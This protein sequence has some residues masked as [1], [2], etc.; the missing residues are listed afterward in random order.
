MG[1]CVGEEETVITTSGNVF[2]LGLLQQIPSSPQTNIFYSPYSIY[3]ALAM[4]YVGARG[5]TQHDLHEALGYSTAGLS[6]ESVASLHARHTR[7]LREPSNSTLL[8]ANAVVVQTGYNVQRQYLDTLRDSFGAE[9]SEADLTDVQSLK[10]INDWVKNKTAGQIEQLLLEPLPSEAKLVLLNAIYFKGL[11]NTPFQA[12]STFKAPFFNA[13]TERVQVDTMHQQI[14]A[15]YAEDDETNAQVVDLTYAGL[16][17]SMVI[18]LPR[19]KNGADAIRR[20]FSVPLYHRLLLKLRERVVD[21]ALPKFKIDKLN[22]LKSNLTFL[23][24]RKMFGSEADLS[25]IT[26]DRRLYVSDVLQR[27]V[28]EVNEEGTE[29]A[30]VTGVIGVNRI[31]IEPFLFT[32]DHPFLFF[33]RDRKTNEI[34]FAGQVNVL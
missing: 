18:I 3:T 21:V 24:L 23:G 16:D 20:N 10:T 12:E 9:V 19:Q 13:G 14:T 26:G 31:G 34:F 2:G 28:V 27:A 17:Y 6:P 32:A 8:V 30:A 7:R 4:A 33:I 22:P 1:Y 25:G 11:W 5:E 29:A 15:G